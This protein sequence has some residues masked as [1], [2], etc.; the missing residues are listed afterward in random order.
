MR[1]RRAARLCGT[2]LDRKY[3]FTFP[4]ITIKRGTTNWDLTAFS[5]NAHLILYLV[6]NFKYCKESLM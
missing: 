4:W 3:F 1:K 5:F 2:L 6:F